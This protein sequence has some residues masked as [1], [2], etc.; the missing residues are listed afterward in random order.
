LKKSG[1]AGT[2][3]T[4]IE[5]AGQIRTEGTGP[6]RGTLYRV[7]QMPP[8]P[9]ASDVPLY[10]DTPSNAMSRTRIAMSPYRGTKQ[11]KNRK[12]NRF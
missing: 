2:R 7:C 8:H 12:R 1:V 5:R 6:H 10:G 4:I 11:E 3:R 9:K